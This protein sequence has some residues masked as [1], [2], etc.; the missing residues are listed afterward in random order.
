MQT[1]EREMSESEGADVLEGVAIIGMA[2]R[3]PRARNLEEYWQNLREGRECISFFTD[4]ELLAAG[5]PAEAVAAPNYVKAGAVLDDIELFDASFF[6]FSPREAEIM[7]PQLR[8]FLECSWEA[9]E[10]AGYDTERHPGAIGIYG[11]M[12]MSKYLLSNILPNRQVVESAGQLQIR[13]WNDKDFLVPLVAYKMNLRG[14]SVTVQTACSTS[15]IAVCMAAQSLL[16][17]QCDMA[18]AGGVTIAVPHRAGTF[19][20]EGVLS[21]DGHCRAFDARARGT[22][23][24]NGLGVVVL[25]RLADAVA[26]GDQVLAVVKGSA[27]NNDGSHKIGYTAPSLDG[28]L[29]VIGM[30]QALAD[31]DPDTVSYI[32]AHGTGTPLGD[33]IEVAA[34][35]E[36]FRA[37]TARK[38]FCAIGSVKT[39]IGHL[40]AAAGVASLI[41]TVL[42]L[43]HAEIP[44]SINFESPNPAIDFANS[45]FFVNARLSEWRRNGTP[46]RA[47]VSSF[48][49]GGVNAHVVLE[50]APPAPASEPG[51]ERA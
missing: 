41:K 18:L 22:V 2:G 14:P 32:E 4:E 3:F 21:P 38:N 29:E 23:A 28:Q 51:G 20:Q 42:A 37:S 6:G 16:S 40:D 36:V 45:P 48:A 19:V 26:D 17:H 5:V 50:E 49:M 27:M 33:P 24:G 35:T 46:R 7:D 1:E 31:V 47:G 15:L 13:I 12:H 11:G 44:P 25:K 30:A 10:A 39:N 43:R 8:L 34:L 9:L